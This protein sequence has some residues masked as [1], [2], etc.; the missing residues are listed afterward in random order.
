[1]F[2]VV[3]LHKIAMTRSQEID[4][5]TSHLRGAQEGDRAGSWIKESFYL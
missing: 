4:V 3:P 5:G 1:M 2:K